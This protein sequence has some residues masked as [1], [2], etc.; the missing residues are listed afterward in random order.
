MVDFLRQAARVVSS[1]EKNHFKEASIKFEEL[2]TPEFYKSLKTIEKNIKETKM[3][4]NNLEK[5]FKALEE[6][7]AVLCYKLYKLNDDDLSDLEK[8]IIYEKARAFFGL[9]SQ[10]QGNFLVLEKKSKLCSSILEG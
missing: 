8:K 10:I 1:L 2:N 6:H 4:L 9:L 3:H 5:N 7:K